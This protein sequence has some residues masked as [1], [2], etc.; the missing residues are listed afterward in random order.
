M[1]NVCIGVNILVIVI[2]IVIINVAG[3]VMTIIVLMSC[4]TQMPHIQTTA[5]TKMHPA[6]TTSTT[7]YLTPLL[8]Q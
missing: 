7:A 6:V 5:D 4:I 3:I 8:R 2:A 1:A